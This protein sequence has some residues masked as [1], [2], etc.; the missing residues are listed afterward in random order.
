MTDKPLRGVMIGAGYFSQFH[1][2]AWRRLAPDVSIVGV[3]DQKEAA[4]SVLAGELGAQGFAPDDLEA[5]IADNAIDFVDIATPPPTH[6]DLCRRVAA[7]GAAILCQKPLGTDYADAEAIVAEMAD[8]R[9]MVHEN[10]RWQPWHRK[11]KALLDEGTL[12]DL[13][14]ITFHARLGDGWQEDAYLAR[15]P[16]FRTYPR[17]FMYETGV[18]FLDLFRFLGGDIASITA[19]LSKRNRDIAGE[20]AAL[21]LCRF[22]SGAS[23]MLDA[24]RYNEP[25]HEDARYTFGTMR[26]DGSKGHLRLEAD[27]SLHLKLLGGPVRRLDFAP[28]RQGFAGDSVF[29]TFQH[30]AGCL[31][32]GAPFE[33]SGA[34][35]LKTLALVEAAYRAEQTGQT[36]CV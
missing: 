15:Q 23:A 2:D 22:A 24:S 3:C 4:A 33:T 7:T 27:G 9:F 36:I 6:R 26:I 12:G 28:S 14:A 19:H 32:S 17:L 13:H 30:F 21:V 18:H 20:D 11:A 8:T 31:R 5:V 35:Y 25:E 10:W 16:Y 1:A 34:Q 29:A